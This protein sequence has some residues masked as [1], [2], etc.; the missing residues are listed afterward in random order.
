M[1]VYNQADSKPEHLF[2]IVVLGGA[3]VGKSSMLEQYV[4]GVFRGQQMCTIGVDFK[5]KRLEIEGKGVKLQMW[6]TAGQERF[7]TI[8]AA[9]YRKAH[10]AAIIYDVTSRESFEEIEKWVSCIRQEARE[11]KLVLL[12][13]KAEMEDKR[14]VSYDE[15]YQVAS[16][17]GLNFYEVSAKTGLGVA[18]GFYD[19]ASQMLKAKEEQALAEPVIKPENDQLKPQQVSKDKGPCC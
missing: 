7:R 9:Y 8:T 3:G 15:G 5:I 12:G 4:D 2:K 13:N 1:P 6:D 14:V 18:D 11:S 19:L 17:L 16:S 10:G